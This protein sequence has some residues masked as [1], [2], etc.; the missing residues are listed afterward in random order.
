[1]LGE[2]GAAVRL[3]LTGLWL[4]QARRG[5]RAGGVTGL[6]GPVC[7]CPGCWRP[8][9]PTP[10]ED[11]CVGALTCPLQVQILSPLRTGSHQTPPGPAQTGRSGVPPTWTR[12][13]RG[14]T[15]GPTQPQVR[16][17]LPPAEGRG[18]RLRP[19]E[20]AVAGPSVVGEQGPSCSRPSA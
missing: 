9:S 11:L 14:V 8:L 7:F 10:Q 1:M 20:K 2:E 18:G 6:A 15:A 13:P 16:C 17:L 4:L 5:G 3:P 19:Q 12:P